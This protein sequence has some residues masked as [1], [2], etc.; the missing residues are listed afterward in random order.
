MH[1]RSLPTAVAV[2]CTA[3][4]TVAVIDAAQNPTQFERIEDHF[5]YR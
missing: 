4:L 1:V 3:L 5:K 2:I